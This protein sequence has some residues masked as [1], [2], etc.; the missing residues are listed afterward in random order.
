MPMWEHFN[1][2][3]HTDHQQEL[4]PRH[5]RDASEAKENDPQWWF[6]DG[7]FNKCDAPETDG[8]DDASDAD[9][10]AG[11]NKHQW[12]DR[13][14]ENAHYWVVIENGSSKIES[15]KFQTRLEI[16]IWTKM[17][18]IGNLCSEGKSIIIFR[19]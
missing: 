10:D 3:G 5:P 17:C 13:A 14:H 16:K 2:H 11:G 4:G 1:K 9:T 6:A 7:L 18:D 19:C 15:R 8:P 12:V